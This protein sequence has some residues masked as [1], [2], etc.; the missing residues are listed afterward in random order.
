MTSL[1]TTGLMLVHPLASLRRMTMNKMVR[2][3]LRLMPTLTARQKPQVNAK[4]TLMP[5]SAADVDA[6]V[7]AAVPA[8]EVATVVA[9]AAIM[10]AMVAMV[11][12]AAASDVDAQLTAVELFQDATE[13]SKLTLSI[14]MSTTSTITTTRSNATTCTFASIVSR[15]ATL[16]KSAA[17]RTS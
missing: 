3:W 13:S 12:S 11:D 5:S 7:L 15:A 10:A 16:A 9:T 6:A 4:L 2:L 14:K 8:A 17:E 1:S